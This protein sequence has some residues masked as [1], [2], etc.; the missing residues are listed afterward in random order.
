MDNFADLISTIGS[1]LMVMQPWNAPLTLTRCWCVLELGHCARKNCK[2][3]VAFTAEER[4]RFLKAI[5]HDATCL[6]DVIANVNS[7]KSSC[8]RPEDRIAI[9]NG[10]SV[11]IGFTKLDRMVFEVLDRWQLQALS[12]QA[13]MCEVE[14]AEHASWFNSLGRMHY[15]QGRIRDAERYFSKA[16]ASA[17]S[18]CDCSDEVFLIAQTNVAVVRYAIARDSEQSSC[19]FTVKQAHKLLTDVVI[20]CR[21]RLQPHNTLLC[22]AVLQLADLHRDMGDIDAAQDLYHEAL[23]YAR[24]LSHEVFAIVAQVGL[25][26]IAQE[27]ALYKEALFMFAEAHKKCEVAAGADHPVT[28]LCRVRQALCLLEVDKGSIS[29]I[30]KGCVSLLP[31]AFMQLCGCDIEKEDTRVFHPARPGTV[32]SETATSAQGIG[33]GGATPSASGIRGHDQFSE[34]SK[35][36][37]SDPA[38]AMLADSFE[39][40]TRTL[41]SKHPQT[42]CTH[43][44]LQVVEAMNRQQPAKDVSCYSQKS[45]VCVS[46]ALIFCCLFI[47]FAHGIYTAIQYLNEREI[48]RIDGNSEIVALPMSIVMNAS[49]G[50]FLHAVG[51]AFRFNGRVVHCGM[52]ILGLP[53]HSS[54]PLIVGLILLIPG[55]ACSPPLPIALSIDATVAVIDMGSCD[56]GTKVITFIFCPS[57]LLYSRFSCVCA[58]ICLAQRAGASGV[59]VISNN[60]SDPIYRME[61]AW[62]SDCLASFAACTRVMCYLVM[63]VYVILLQEQ[64]LVTFVLPRSWYRF[65]TGTLCA[66]PLVSPSIQ[67]FTPLISFQPNSTQMSC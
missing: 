66:T 1:V 49:A 52:Q 67:A 43:A 10:I 7:M 50:K 39:R 44:W 32:H 61:G 42:K 17:S 54:P 2:F 55:T 9:L 14:G 62:C 3:D 53:N 29:H 18:T 26:L 30:W 37:C 25:A 65:R 60:S 11:S 6:F 38:Y 51:A 40:C 24:S 47:V 48:W 46:F 12:S 31:T 41:G 19:P 13:H 36:L 56:F 45:P 15:E 22:T 33:G 21:T 23:Q 5:R 34:T 57:T 8:S 58:Q 35:F 63:F 59:V 20:S 28:I 4:A 64:H 16:A 27:K